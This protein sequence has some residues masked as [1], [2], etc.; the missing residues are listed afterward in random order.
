MESVEEN[1]QQF[2]AVT[3]DRNFTHIHTEPIIP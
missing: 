2:T 3:Q 1:D